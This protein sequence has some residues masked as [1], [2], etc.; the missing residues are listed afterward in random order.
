MQIQVFPDET[1][2][3]AQAKQAVEVQLLQLFG[4]AV[5]SAPVEKNPE[6]HTEHKV[7]VEFEVHVRQL[8]ITNGQAAHVK[9]RLL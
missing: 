9:V 1:K 5:H 3:E 8:G 7:V 4:Q 6:P 2:V